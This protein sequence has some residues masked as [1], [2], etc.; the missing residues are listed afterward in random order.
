MSLTDPELIVRT[1]ASSVPYCE[2]L[3][4]VG[5]AACSSR[6]FSLSSFRCN[7]PHTSEAF[8]FVNTGPSAASIAAASIVAF[9]NAAS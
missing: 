7:F 1:L 2:G 5:H 6:F 9:G 8:C 4:A 3:R